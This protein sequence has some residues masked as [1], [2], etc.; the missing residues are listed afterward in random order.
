MT[1]GTGCGGGSGSDDKDRIFTDEEIVALSDDLIEDIEA[2]SDADQLAG[3]LEVEQAVAGYDYTIPS[4]PGDP[5]IYNLEPSDQPQL[6]QMHA[7]IALLGGS[8]SA[9]LWCSL[10][11]VRLKPDDP[12]ALSEAGVILLQLDEDED[13]QAFLR[14]AVY[15]DENEELYHLSLANA[16]KSLGKVPQALDQA[17]K[18]LEL[19]PDNMVVKNAVMQMY[20]D[21]L[22]QEIRD[23]RSAMVSACTAHIQ[24]AVSLKDL[25]EVGAFTQATQQASSDMGTDLAEHAMGMPMDFPMGFIEELSN[26]QSGCMDRWTNSYWGPLSQDLDD[27][28]N[29]SFDEQ[30][31]FAV[32]LSDCCG[33]TVPCPCQCFYDYCTDNLMLHEDHTVPDSYEAMES[34]LVGSL[35]D[36]KNR[37]LETVGEIIRNLPQLSQSSAEWAVKYEYLML[38]MHCLSIGQGA[39]DVL[40]VVYGE[41]TVVT[42][43]CQ[44]EQICRTA[45]EE[46]RQAAWKQRIEEERLAE[47]ERVRQK[48]LAKQK[49]QEDN[50]KGEVCLDSIGC[51][52][53]DGSKVSV[54]IGGPVFAQFT[55]DTDRAAV[56]VRVG[57]GVSDPSGGNLAGG[58]LSIGGEISTSGSS[59]FDVRASY[60]FAAGTKSGNVVLFGAAYNN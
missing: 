49:A 46:A 22:S 34:F 5:G 44:M 14:K 37:E 29:Y 10:Q 23:Q 39:A 41:A 2:D 16:Y 1:A 7:V 19:A 27:I 58:D 3:F 11:A 51:L 50:I 54:K 21:D 57:V 59:T 4:G 13:A 60:S 30:D 9:A 24:Q 17:K 35:I 53:I 40:G 28:Q 31:S 48:A 52:G 42:A 56:G 6:Y 20:M 38:G 15:E 18:A 47:E 33:T 8:R 25:D 12:E 32:D 36:F 45:E 43:N 55:V 26:L